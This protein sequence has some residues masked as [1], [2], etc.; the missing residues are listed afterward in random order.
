MSNKYDP[1]RKHLL[2]VQENI[3]ECTLS[4]PDIER[5]IGQTLPFSALNHR[6]WW[7]NQARLDNRPQAKAWV[8][9][10]FM[11][12]TVHQ[13]VGGWVRFKR[14]K[15]CAGPTMEAR[16]EIVT[17]NTCPFCSLPRERFIL[18]NALGVVIRDGFPVSAGHTLI[19]PR[20]HVSS[21]FGLLEDEREALLALL[22]EAKRGLEKEFR[23]QGYNIGIN[24]GPAAGQTVPHLHIHLIPRY[25][26][27]QADP[28]G[29]V[30]W[31][32]PEKADYWSHR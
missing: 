13:G 15:I 16:S 27:D 29:G 30:R 6:A 26:G 3:L 1:L 17:E 4:F 14:T 8:D 2:A 28:R 18:S 24:D 25:Q 12:D 11:V 23:P 20:R 32:I 10:G 19:I 5:L 9:A 22:E 7:S 21:Y 31:V